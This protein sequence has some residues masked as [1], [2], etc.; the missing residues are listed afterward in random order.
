MRHSQVEGKDPESGVVYYFNE[1]TGKSQWER[2]AV[3]ALVPPP[4]PPP[5]LPPLPSDWEEATD[6]G[7]GRFTPR[8]LWKYFIISL[9]LLLE[10]LK[11][12]SFVKTAFD[13]LEN[14]SLVGPDKTGHR[15]Y[16]NVKTNESSWERPKVAPATTDQDKSG[17]GEVATNGAASKFKKCLGCGG[18][19]RGLVQAWNYC[20]HCTRCL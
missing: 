18:W 11:E 9:V 3:K 4:P 19:G 15:Y 7:T 8:L 13:I 10:L 1:S 20:N 5:A 16:Y 17:T 14:F 12:P 2:P 6:S